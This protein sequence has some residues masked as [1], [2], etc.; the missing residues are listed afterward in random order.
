MIRK[1]AKTSDHSLFAYCHSVHCSW[2]KL[3]TRQGLTISHSTDS[4]SDSKQF[5]DIL[6]Q[7]IRKENMV[8][9]CKIWMPARVGN[10]L[11]VMQVDFTSMLRGDVVG[12]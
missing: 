6:L 9:Y 1:G 2:K 8:K 12:A 11:L 10:V 5:L 7:E 4:L 3:E